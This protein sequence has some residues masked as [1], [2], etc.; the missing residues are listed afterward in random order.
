VFAGQT[1]WKNL[2][3][4][5]V[6]L[7]QGSA[8][9]SIESSDLQAS[10]ISIT[11]PGGGRVIGQGTVQLAGTFPF[12][13]K[14]TVIDL[15]FLELLGGLGVSTNAIDFRMGVV[16]LAIDGDGVALDPKKRFR[17]NFSGSVAA[18][19]LVVP[20][21]AA[22]NIENFTLPDCRIELGLR[23]SGEELDFDGTRLGCRPGEPNVIIPSGR[24]S[25]RDSQT[26]FELK[27]KDFDLSSVSY[28]SGLKMAGAADFEGWIK[29]AAS[30]DGVSF[31]ADIAAQDF[32]FW[33]FGPAQ[34]R[35]H[36]RIDEDGLLLTRMNVIPQDQR[37]TGVALRSNRVFLSFDDALS[38]FGVD[39]E[40]PLQSLRHFAP[41]HKQLESIAGES[42]KLSLMW[43]MDLD[44]K[45]VSSLQVDAKVSEVRIGNF[46]ATEVVGKVSC[47]GY[48][49][50][51]STINLSGPS[52]Q[53]AGASKS[54][55]RVG[56]KI[57]DISAETFES[58]IVFREVPLGQPDGQDFRCLLNGRIDLSGPLLEGFPG[59]TGRVSCDDLTRGGIALGQIAIDVQSLEAGSPSRMTRQIDLDFK[60]AF[61]Q[62]AGRI[63]IPVEPQGVVSAVLDAKNFDPMTWFAAARIEHNLFSSMTGQV[64]IETPSP[65]SGIGFG[66]DQWQDQVA[67]RA[68]ISSF[69]ISSDGVRAQTTQ[70]VEIGWKERVL[71]V[72]RIALRSFRSLMAG[73]PDLAPSP[74]GLGGRPGSSNGK[75]QVV[76]SPTSQQSIGSEESVLRA[77]LVHDFASGNGKSSVSGQLDL[78]LLRGFTGFI[79]SASGT[80]TLDSSLSFT[81]SGPALKGEILLNAD[82]LRIKDFE[83][84]I[85]ALTGRIAMNGDRLEILRLNGKKGQGDFELLG[86]VRLP[87]EG[88][89][90]EPEIGL[91]ARLNKVQTRVPAPVFRSVDLTAS[92][93]VELS[94]KGRPYDLRGS[95]TVDRLRAFRDLECD[96]IVD[97]LPQGSSEKFRT[98]LDPWLS[99]DVLIESPDSIQLLTRCARSNFSSRLKITGT[100]LTPRFSGSVSADSGVV[101]V[102]KARFTVQRAEIAFDSPIAFDPRLDIQL[103]AQIESY[104]VFMNID[105]YSSSPRTSFWSEPSTT[106]WGTPVGQAEIL[107]MVSTGRAPKAESGQANVLASQ[108]A[109]YV[110]GSTA[111]DESLTKA[112]SRLT[113]GFVDTVQLQPFIE[114]GQTAWK[115]TLSRGIGERF[116]L[117]LDVEQSPIANNQSLTGTLYLNQ[118]VN[119]LGGF[120][121]K[122]NPSES[123][124]EVSG[125]LRFMF[126]GK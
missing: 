74:D 1:S 111:L 98:E 94:G 121:R 59:P 64:L 63:S 55:G 78:G 71:S 34:V 5:D 117:G 21:V 88:R 93:A 18:T 60:A 42:R 36:L 49:C 116:N 113:A 102:L 3:I 43:D 96:E 53:S 4:D 20:S 103:V 62:L 6:A 66:S 105:G 85:E 80:L 30:G 26:S 76:P 31:E 10:L 45:Q 35:T 87:F 17:L 110:Y 84:D 33:G 23:V 108:V 95:V 41:E 75:V 14:V 44:S 38:S 39:I 37:M 56:I 100:E 126:G 125:G 40:G 65:F 57:H 83:P 92:G 73:S 101:Q 120:D 67:A 29:S 19:N 70:P 124:Y 12:E 79:E 106:P 91:R 77:E 61:D 52:I 90:K 27:A 8:D 48:R 68:S 50:S 46:Y 15:G 107:R 54:Q 122:S 81:P 11:T 9:V 69:S 51:S 2:V 28:F 104:Q 32:I 99:F 82:R 58:E 72:R 114:N 22:Q 89:R 13:A 109:N 115:A 86:S 24:I 97:A 118:S 119:V 47:D 16:D 123:Y 112:L 7:Y 25:L